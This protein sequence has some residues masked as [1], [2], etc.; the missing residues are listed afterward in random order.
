M[1]AMVLDSPGTP[2]REAEL[3][4]P[5][6]GPGQV[7]VEVAACGVCRTDLHV[8]DGELP[9]PKLPLVPGHQVVGRVVGKERSRRRPRRRPVAR[10]DVRRVPLLPERAR[11]PLRP[12]ALHRLPPRRRLR[13]AP[14]RG[15]A[16]LLSAPGGLRRPAGGAAPLRRADRLPRAPARRR[17]R[18]A[19]ALRLRR[20]RAHRRAGRTPPG[21]AR[22]RL[23][24]RRRRGGAG[25]RAGARRGVGGRT[26]RSAPPEELDAAIVFAPVGRARA[27]GAGRRRRR[28]ARSSAPGST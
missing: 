8:V 17:R 25:L 23:H 4:A 21:P 1:K 22:L 28:A 5:E 20:E 2:L 15:R 11:E 27:G 13:G 12:R 7:L 6:P 24:A 14:R 26:P 10:L 18:A 9:D 16:L 3:P 19:R